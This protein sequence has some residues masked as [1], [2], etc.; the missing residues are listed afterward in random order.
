M[1]L[2]YSFKKSYKLK[3]ISKKLALE[4]DKT[5]SFF[6]QDEKEFSSF[7]KID[8]LW[9]EIFDFCENDKFTKEDLEYCNATRDDLEIIRDKLF[10]NGGLSYSKGHLVIVSVFFYSYPLYF[11]LSQQRLGLSDFEMT[12]RCIQYFDKNEMG[13]IIPYWK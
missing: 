8:E 6:L 13:T 11:C 7:K 4:L 12:Q 9:N 2:I 1:P 3:K 10:K 5:K